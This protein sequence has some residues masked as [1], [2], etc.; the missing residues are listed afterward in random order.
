[1]ACTAHEIYLVDEIKND[2]GGG[3]YGRG[4]RL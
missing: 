1:M 2:E 4:E 3:R